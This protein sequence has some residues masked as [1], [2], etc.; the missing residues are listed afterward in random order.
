MDAIE[1]ALRDYGID[2]IL[3]ERGSNFNDLMFEIELALDQ[4][5]FINV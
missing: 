1:G 3:E 5:G 2:W 4:G